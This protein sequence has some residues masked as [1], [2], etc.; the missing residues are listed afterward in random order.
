MDAM[1]TPSL[2]RFLE[3]K[4]KIAA[5]NA[6]AINKYVLG[7]KMADIKR[8]AAEIP[9]IRIVP[10]RPDLY[11]TIMKEAYTKADPV[12]FCNMISSAG[13][14]IIA[15]EISLVRKSF[16]LMCRELRYL[17]TAMQVANLANSAGCMRKNP[18][19][20]QDLAPLTS[21]PKI[22]TPIRESITMKY[23]I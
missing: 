7:T 1:I 11:K 20:Y 17:A 22:K 14:I 10:G 8:M 16:I 6:K 12:S 18:K 23:M 13:S 4:K 2:N 5:S 15:P 3:K 19:S 21:I 9:K